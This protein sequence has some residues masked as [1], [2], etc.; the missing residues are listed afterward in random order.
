[1]ALFGAK[2]GVFLAQNHPFGDIIQFFYT[3]MAG[4][5]KDNFLCCLRRTLSLGAAT[6]AK[7]Q[8]F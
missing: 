2:S 5:H 4:H 7:K 3:I 8:H 6:R 1:M